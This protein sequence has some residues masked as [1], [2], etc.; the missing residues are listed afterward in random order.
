M[1]PT[2]GVSLPSASVLIHSYLIFFSFLSDLYTAPTAEPSSADTTTTAYPTTDTLPKCAYFTST[3]Y[4][5]EP[6]VMHKCHKLAF[7]SSEWSSFACDWSGGSVE[8]ITYSDANCQSP[9]AT[10]T[11]TGVY[12]YQCGNQYLGSACTYTKYSEYQN[13]SSDVDAG[14]DTG[15]GESI[16]KYIAM[17]VCAYGAFSLTSGETFNYEMDICDGFTAP[18]TGYDRIAYA[19]YQCQISS[20]LW[21]TIP[22]LCL[23]PFDSSGLG[24][25]RRRMEEGPPNSRLEQECV[26]PWTIVDNTGS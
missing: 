20:G 26:L 16:V 15:I 12:D 4:D 23:F 6:L 21:E 17:D 9:V 14:V 22:N 5:M 10:S 19:D 1:A 24:P 13:C 2:P 25:Q 18:S 3:E 7:N 8:K 11:V